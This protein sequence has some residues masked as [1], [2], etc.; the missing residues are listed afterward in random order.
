MAASIAVRNIA[1][2]VR[3]VEEGHRATLLPGGAIR[4]VSDTHHGKGYRVEFSALAAGEPIRWS[5]QPEGRAAFT[6]D[7]LLVTASDG[8]LPCK[9]A[10]GAARRLEREG[11]AA[12]DRLGRWV[13]T[14]KAVPAA[15]PAPAD[16]FEGLT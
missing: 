12:L 8:S 1:A 7:H 2:E 14:E 16:P 6:D 4:V 9:H 5:C 15:P 3:F 11:L 10:A 13:A